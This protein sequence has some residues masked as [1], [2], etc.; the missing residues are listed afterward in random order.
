MLLFIW[1]MYKLWAVL[2]TGTPIWSLIPPVGDY[3]ILLLF[4]INCFWL[5]RRFVVSWFCKL[6][7]WSAAWCVRL[8][9][10]FSPIWNCCSCSWGYYG[11]LNNL[12]E[13][14][15]A[16]IIWLLLLC[17]CYLWLIILCVELLI[18]GMLLLFRN[19]ECIALLICN[20]PF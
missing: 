18:W 1:F 8:I 3:Y 17:D 13:V 9:M 7:F 10:S 16:D 14:F 2:V 4:L 19:S 15:G 11:S 12:L 6:L 20:P 5:L